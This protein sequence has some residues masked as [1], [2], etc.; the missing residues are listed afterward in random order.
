MRELSTHKAGERL[1]WPDSPAG[2]A[3]ATLRPMQ[4][5]GFVLFLALSATLAVVA[6]EP[7]PADGLGHLALRTVSPGHLLRPNVGYASTETLGAGRYALRAALTLGNVWLH[8]QDAYLMDG[9]WF[10]ADVTLTRA[11][12]ENFRL[13]VG[14]PIIGRSGGVGD[15]A[16]EWFHRTVRIG[17]A[18]REDFPRNRFR[19]RFTG[20][21]GRTFED[22]DESWGIGDVP[23]FATLVHRSRA[24]RGP[25]LFAH[26]GLTLPT[27]RQRRLEGLGNPLWGGSLLAFQRLGRSRWVVYGGGSFTHAPARRLAGIELRSEELSALTGVRFDLT[28]RT[29]LLAQY[30]LTS[31][32]ARRYHTFSEPAHEVQ[33]GVKHRLR[34]GLVIEVA[35]VENVFRFSN[36]A[37]VG[38]HAALTWQW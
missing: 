5:G 29:A 34:E 18:N 13:S 23:V 8:R 38:V 16:I 4:L 19:I 6:D 30:L 15:G 7:P 11:V 26:L 28:D 25:V 12:S 35:L 1:R 27:G 33:L 37:D 36:S 3:A 17:N 14:L 31:P 21:D 22:D 9:E 24:A 20:P 10:A 32:V 2:A